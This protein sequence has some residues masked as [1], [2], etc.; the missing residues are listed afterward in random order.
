MYYRNVAKDALKHAKDALDNDKD[1]YLIYA[2]LELRMALE[3][4]VYERAG[5]FTA[6][7][8]EKELNTWQP[9]KLLNILLEIDPF[10]DKSPDI[11]IGIEEEFC[12]PPETMK[13]MGKERV[14]SLKEIKQFYNRLGSYIHTKTKE[15]VEKNKGANAD[16]IRKNC[17]DLYNI[18]S[19]V[20]DS[21]IINFDMKVITKRTCDNCGKEIARRIIPTKKSFIAKCIECGVSYNVETIEKDKVRWNP[22]GTYVRC[23][24]K[25]CDYQFFL[26]ESETKVGTNWICY[27]CKQPNIIALALT[28]DTNKV[29]NK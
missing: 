1:H 18:I 27:K 13:F 10:I 26:F 7:I 29:D 9:G 4:L 12:K 6:E 8:T 22:I 24:N 2:A 25:D 20:V 3:A 5:L 11:F 21:Q 28:I 19:E 16:K 23:A 14:L 15:Q 17:N